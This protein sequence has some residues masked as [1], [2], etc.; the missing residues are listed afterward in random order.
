VS[1]RF[2]MRRIRCPGTSGALGGGQVGLKHFRRGSL[3]APP[4]SRRGA[5][6]F[7]RRLAEFTRAFTV[8]LAS[9][10]FAQTKKPELLKRWE[11][12]LGPLH[13]VARVGKPSLRRE[14]RL[15]RPDGRRIADKLC[16]GQIDKRAN[17]AIASMMRGER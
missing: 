17:L 1:W 13:F 10:S 4:R 14:G 2:V 8:A 12:D 11:D 16:D 7:Y 15:V 9:P 6:G 5:R 3:C